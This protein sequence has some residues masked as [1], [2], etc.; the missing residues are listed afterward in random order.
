L[1][2][3]FWNPF[4]PFMAEILIWV[5]WL[6]VSVYI[7]LR[8]SFFLWFSRAIGCG[9][10]NAT[11]EEE[12]LICNESCEDNFTAPGKSRGMVILSP[13]LILLIW[14]FGSI[15]Q[16]GLGSD[17]FL[18]IRRFF[19]KQSWEEVSGGWLIL[20]RKAWMT[21]GCAQTSD[22]L[23]DA[24]RPEFTQAPF[25]LLLYLLRNCIEMRWLH[26]DRVFECDVL[27]A[28]LGPRFGVYYLKNRSSWFANVQS[29]PLWGL[30]Q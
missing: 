22:W 17:L 29:L 20:P 21:G 9:E 5:W 6:A 25:D 8:G 4:N 16:C 13:M 14:R 11:R 10:K 26:G 23:R 24:L 12:V 1:S 30:Y 19:L 7:T 2:F 15:R 27:P 18:V 28:I 3:K